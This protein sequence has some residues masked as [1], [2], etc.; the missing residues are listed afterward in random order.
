MFV[1]MPYF[2]FIDKFL[3]ACGTSPWDDI[4]IERSVVSPWV[5]T[6]I[7]RRIVSPWVDTV[8]VGGLYHR[9]LTQLL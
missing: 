2:F 8:I 5:D 3:G 6:V 7:V 9:G 4:V 1:L